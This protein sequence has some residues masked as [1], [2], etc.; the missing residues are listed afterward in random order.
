MAKQLSFQERRKL[1]RNLFGKCTIRPQESSKEFLLLRRRINYNINFSEPVGHL[2][3]VR[4]WEIPGELLI[5]APNLPKL[6]KNPPMPILV[7]QASSF[8]Q[9]MKTLDDSKTVMLDLEGNDDCYA[10]KCLRILSNDTY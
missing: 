10:G 3:Q 8:A 9:M 6:T 5:T 2:E 1:A 4:N 7:N